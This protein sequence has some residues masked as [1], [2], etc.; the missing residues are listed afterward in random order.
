MKVI[1]LQD[2]AK[3]GRRFDIVEVPSGYGMNKLIPQG[4][5][6]P[7]TPENVKAVQAQAASNEAAK[8]QA[9]EAFTEL[10]SKA[11]EA[12]ISITVDANEEGRLFQAIKPEVIAETIAQQTGQEVPLEQIVIKSPIKELGEH[13]IELVSG[14]TVVT[15]TITVKPK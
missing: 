6:K 14:D 11:K 3:I 7:A 10:V 12:D 5:A 15:L 13:T 1:L 2:V 8:A 4:M 9:D